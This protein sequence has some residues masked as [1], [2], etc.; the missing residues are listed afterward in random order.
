MLSRCVPEVPEAKVSCGTLKKQRRERR[1]AHMA[2][3]RFLSGKPIKKP[4]SREAAAAD[5]TP[6]STMDRIN[7]VILL[8]PGFLHMGL[9][10]AETNCGR[11]R[12]QNWNNS[13]A[14]GM[15]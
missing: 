5:N 15:K 7:F 14:K 9:L 3:W 11:T 6:V 4:R 8:F 1:R 10:L 13:S 12:F 2:V